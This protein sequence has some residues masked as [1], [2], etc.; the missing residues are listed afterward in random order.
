MKKIILLL[1]FVSTCTTFAISNESNTGKSVEEIELTLMLELE[2][3]NL[4]FGNATMIDPCQAACAV[5]WGGCTLLCAGDLLCKQICNQSYEGC[6]QLC[7]GPVG[8]PDF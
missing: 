5:A 8:N 3:G 4:D 6:L 1:L 7:G 2:Q